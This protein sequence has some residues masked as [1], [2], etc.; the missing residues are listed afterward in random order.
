MHKIIRIIR[1]FD[2]LVW[3]GLVW[4]PKLKYQ[5]GFDQCVNVFWMDFGL[6]SRVGTLAATF[7]QRGG[8][9]RKVG[10]LPLLV[11]PGFARSAKLPEL[12]DR[13]K[14]FCTELQKTAATALSCNFWFWRSMGAALVT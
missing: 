8:K 3:Y 9:V 12:D 11:C 10:P 14:T 7:S 1:I 5:I 2:S 13:H 6:T 4:K